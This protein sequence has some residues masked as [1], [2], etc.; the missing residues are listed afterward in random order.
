MAVSRIW[1][2]KGKIYL[3]EVVE[4]IYIL[5]FSFGLKATVLAI[6]LEKCSMLSSLICKFSNFDSPDMNAN[7]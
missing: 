6:E 4:L 1:H 3:L 2:L 5:F 7:L